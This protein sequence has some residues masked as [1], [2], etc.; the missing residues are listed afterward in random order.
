MIWQ[1]GEAEK[2]LAGPNGVNIYTQLIDEAEGL[3]KIEDLQTHENEEI[4]DKAAN[5][6][7]Q[8]F[9]VGYPPYTSNTRK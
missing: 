3:D 8:F 2:E 5:M 7:E 9:E 1:V 6:L 4:Y